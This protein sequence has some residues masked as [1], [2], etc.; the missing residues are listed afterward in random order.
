MDG[1]FELAE[2]FVFV[3]DPVNPTCGDCSTGGTGGIL[4]VF[5]LLALARRFLPAA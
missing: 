2:G 3:D 1:L 4:M 5:L